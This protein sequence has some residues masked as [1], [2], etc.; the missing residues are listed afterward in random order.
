MV[1]CKTTHFATNISVPANDRLRKHFLDDCVAMY[2]IKLKGTFEAITICSITVVYTSLLF[3]F[4]RL[5]TIAVR[6]KNS[7]I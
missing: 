1:I 4:E 3:Y 7:R 5:T 2:V 6:S